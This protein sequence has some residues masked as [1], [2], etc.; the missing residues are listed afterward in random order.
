MLEI[1]KASIFG[2]LF[3]S[4]CLIATTCADE[5]RWRRRRRDKTY[6]GVDRRDPR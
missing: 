2:L 5:R 1:I 3:L 6:T 4:P